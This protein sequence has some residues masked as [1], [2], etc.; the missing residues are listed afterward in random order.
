LYGFPTGCRLRDPALYLQDGLE[1]H[2]DAGGAPLAA[3]LGLRARR[4]SAASCSDASKRAFSFA[5][6][7]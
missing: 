3:G 1:R 7:A 2:G 6:M 5:R 4:A